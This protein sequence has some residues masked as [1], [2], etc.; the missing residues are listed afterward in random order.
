M[1][2]LSEFVVQAYRPDCSFCGVR[3]KS[4]EFWD[5][6]KFVAMLVLSYA[7]LGGLGLNK[8]PEVKDGARFGSLR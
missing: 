7:I 3:S 2:L 5:S 1:S 8:L 6:H 4:Q